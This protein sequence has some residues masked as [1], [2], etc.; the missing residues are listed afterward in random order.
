FFEN[1]KGDTALTAGVY[2]IMTGVATG[3]GLAIA[4]KIYNRV[5]ARF[6]IVSGMILL[7]VGTYG[8]TQLTVDTTWASLQFWVCV[9]GVGVGFTTQSL[10]VLALSVVSNR[11]MARASSLYNVTRQVAGAVG[12]AAL[13]AFLTQQATTHATDIGRALQVGLQTHQL[14]GDAAAC[15]R[16]VPLTPQGLQ[17]CV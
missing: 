9:R 15:A 2:M 10:Q 3:V 1:V 17:A 14:T 16:I 7:A 13:A 8:L 4:G 11:A 5:G 6:L 12:I